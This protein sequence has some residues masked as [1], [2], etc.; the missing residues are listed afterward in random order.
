MMQTEIGWPFF[1]SV[2]SPRL[3]DKT[4]IIKIGP[5][6]DTLQKNA[7]PI[8]SEE[9]SE[10][11]NLFWV[12]LSNIFQSCYLNSQQWMS[13]VSIVTMYNIILQDNDDDVLRKLAFLLYDAVRATL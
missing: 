8:H 12:F 2:T 11:E 3:S 6:E 10:H 5:A 13:P 1:N 7:W 4:S 9:L